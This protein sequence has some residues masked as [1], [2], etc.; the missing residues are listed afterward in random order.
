MPFKFHLKKSRQYNVVSRNQYVIC[1]EL[2]DTGSIECTLDIQSLGHECLTNVT[3]RLGLGQPEFFGLSYISRDGA[4][5]S[6]WVQMDKPLKRQLEK[7]A[8]NFNLQL[9]V[10][11]FVTDIQ[12]IQDE[13]TR[14]HYYLQLKMDVIEGRIHCDP[15]EASTLASYSMQ[16]EFGNYDSQRHTVEYLRQCL[17]FPK[18]IIQADPGGIDVLLSAAIIRY[19]SL[20][21]LTQ[22]AAEE[23]YVS[24][25]VQLEGYG[26]ETFAA[27]DDANNEIF[28]GISI[29]GIIIGYSDVQLT[30]FYGWKD[31]SNVINHKKTFRIECQSENE[32]SKQFQFNKARTAKYVWRLCI[33]QHTFYIQHQESNLA[34]KMTNNQLEP[35]NIDLRDE[36]TEVNVDN[37]PKGD[38]QAH[39]RS[40]NDISSSPFPVVTSS[41]DMN[42]LRALLPSYRPAPDYDTAVQRKYNTAPNGSHH[43]YANQP[44]VQSSSLAHEVCMSTI[45]SPEL[46]CLLGNAVNRS[47]Y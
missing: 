10:M 19:K 42:T 41:I 1:V 15:R 17:L 24:I 8:R 25:A 39:F 27:K 29:N 31:I 22:A 23:L 46:S 20:A 33:A 6:R 16:A 45:I 47:R 14:Y 5:T 34:N 21:G 2:L 40:C 38:C 32:D 12:L 4:P 35:D 43:F 30:S 13:I 18:N 11:Y 3:Q 9:R 28:L 37:E 36:I 44:N 26:R 7:E